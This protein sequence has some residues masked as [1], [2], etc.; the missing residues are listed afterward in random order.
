VLRLSSEKSPEVPYGA[1]AV[2][3]SMEE[4][5]AFAP[6]AA[7]ICSPASEHLRVAT[8]LVHAGIAVMVEKPL[9]H[10]SE[11]IDDLLEQAR[12]RNV[13]LMT[14]Y[15]LRFLP[16]L[17]EARRLVLSGVIGEVFGVRAEVGQYLPD[18][19]PAARYQDSVAA[20]Q[21]LGGGALLELSHEID[22][23]TWIIGSPTRVFSCGGRFGALEIDVEDM[24]SLVLEY[25][26]PRLMATIHV[27][28]LQRAASRTCKFIGSAG[29]LVWDGIAETIA[30]YGANT[31]EWTHWELRASP[32]KN[33]MYLDELSHFLEAVERRTPVMI[34]G[35]QGLQVLRIV[36]AAKRSIATR[37]AV[38]LR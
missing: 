30:V 33:A 6:T 31:S 29:T 37:T 20:M 8:A 28:F 19:R 38:E 5:L 4:A 3:K 14:A 13:P 18:W 23:I 15:N 25:D 10:K 35:Q 9:A 16:S 11:G 22:Y 27:D 21:C 34:D 26:Q 12:I 32:D 24:A 17:A 2:F 1:D 7:I 36:E